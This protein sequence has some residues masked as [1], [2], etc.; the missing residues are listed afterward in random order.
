MYLCIKNVYY[1]NENGGKETILLFIIIYYAREQIYFLSNISYRFI[2][3]LEFHT[4]LKLK[5][6]KSFRSISIYCKK[7]DKLHLCLESYQ[8]LIIKI[9]FSCSTFIFNESEQKSDIS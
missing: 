2:I 8:G 3:F 4:I 7:V 9:E 1:V 5:Y 6:P